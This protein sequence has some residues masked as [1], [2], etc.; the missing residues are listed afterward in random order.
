[1]KSLPDIIVYL[2]TRAA[3]GRNARLAPATAGA[4]ARELGRLLALDRERH[5]GSAAAGAESPMIY[6]LDEWTA[7]GNGIA[8]THAWLG[9][10]DM[11]AAAWHV[12]TTRTAAGRRLTWRHGARVIQEAGTAQPQ[13]PEP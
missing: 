12:L 13:S 5:H 3:A 9:D 1:M 11:A 8:R 2:T 6:R 7:D 10:F 4:L